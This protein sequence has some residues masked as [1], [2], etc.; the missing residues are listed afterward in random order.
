MAIKKLEDINIL[1]VGHSIQMAGA[2]YV[3]E[4]KAYLA[5]FPDEHMAFVQ[6]DVHL[7]PPGEGFHDIERWVEVETL[8]MGPAEWETF[9][10]QTDLLE[11]E[12]SAKAANGTVEKAIV[13]K[14]QRQ[15]EQG[16]SWRVF[17]RDGYAC[18]YCA[19]SDVPLTVDHLVTW[20]AG[21]PSIVDNL[22]SACRKCNKVRGDLG[23]PE[24][25]QHAYYQK[26]SQNLSEA[27]RTANVRLVETLDKIP[28]LVHKR[29]R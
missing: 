21:G 26:V 10:R 16:V 14:S 24:W 13:R 3:G 2:I 25:L 27:V 11:T 15:I 22:V 19:N 29:S 8:L 12:V 1:S 5:F 18:R 20:E 17:K 28:R 4:G 7:R 6:K 9:L 23:Y